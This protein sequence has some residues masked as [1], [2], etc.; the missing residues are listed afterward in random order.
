[1]E[2]KVEKEESRPG[3]E[4]QGYGHAIKCSCDEWIEVEP[5]PEMTPGTARTQAHEMWMVH[6]E[7]G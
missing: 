1:M 4:G 5:M 3:S 2:H 7:E 6:A